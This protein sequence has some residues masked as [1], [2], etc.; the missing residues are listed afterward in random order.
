MA[1]FERFWNASLPAAPGLTVVEIT[2]AIHAGTIR[3]MFIMGENPAMSDPDAAHARAAL[4]KL[5]HLVVQDLFPTETAGYADVILPAT[6]FF[7]KTGTFT[8]TDRT[9]QLARRVLEPPGRRAG[10]PVDTAADSRR[11]SASTGGTPGPITASRP[12]T[13]KCAGRC[14]RS[15]AFRGRGSSA[16]AP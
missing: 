13:R 12:F 10:G 8:N 7:E 6:S 16:T 5:E 2:E 11:D 1:W 4:A 9:V 3:G 15:P 14:H